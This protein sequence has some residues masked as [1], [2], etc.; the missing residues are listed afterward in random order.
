MSSFR[1]TLPRRVHVVLSFFQDAE[2][3]HVMSLTSGVLTWE[4]PQVFGFQWQSVNVLHCRNM[5]KEAWAL[6]TACVS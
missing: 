3:S 4:W 2:T 1:I 5:Q 6:S